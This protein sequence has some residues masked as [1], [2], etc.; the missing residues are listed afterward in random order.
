[1]HPSVQSA[2]CICHTAISCYSLLLL[3]RPAELSGDSPAPS[4]CHLL[5]PLLLTAAPPALLLPAPAPASDRAL[6]ALTLPAPAAAPAAASNPA[7]SDLTD[8]LS[9][10]LPLRMEDC[11]LLCGEWNS[12]LLSDRGD[13]CC[14]CCCCWALPLLLTDVRLPLGSVCACALPGKLCA[15]CAASCCLALTGV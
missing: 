11:L 7:D 5:L 14:C 3:T 4:C 9:D 2:V 1:M 6:Y 12:L 8:T 15:A 13:C 10:S